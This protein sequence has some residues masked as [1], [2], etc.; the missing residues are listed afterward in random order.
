MLNPTCV[1]GLRLNDTPTGSQVLHLV[2]D[3]KT[4][5]QDTLIMALGTTLQG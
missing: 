3:G 5:A 1:I 4:F 2:L